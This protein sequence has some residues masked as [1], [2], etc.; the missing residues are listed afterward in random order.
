METIKVKS[1]NGMKVELIKNSKTK[2]TVKAYKQNKLFNQKEGLTLDLANQ[3]YQQT[4]IAM[5][6]MATLEKMISAIS[7]SIV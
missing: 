6:Q 5:L 7:E 2:F 4:A 3:C 1:A